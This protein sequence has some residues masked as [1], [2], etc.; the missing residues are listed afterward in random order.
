MFTLLMFHV[1]IGQ[2]K[3]YL[4]LKKLQSCELSDVV[5]KPLHP[6]KYIKLLN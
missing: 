1:D 3:Q 4:L 2:G 6:L 5:E